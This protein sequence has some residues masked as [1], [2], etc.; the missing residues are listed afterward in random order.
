M[1]DTHTPSSELFL[2]KKEDFDRVKREGRRRPTSLFNVMFCLTS[3]SRTRVGIVVGKRFGKAVARNR[4]KRIFRE[5]VRKTHGL[6]V[7]GQDIVVFPKR[8]ILTCNHQALYD[9]WVKV[10][11]REGLMSPIKPLPCVKQP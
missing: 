8:P 4:G 5:V 2:K 11:M 1:S 6:L 9:S 3:T 10:L 7:K